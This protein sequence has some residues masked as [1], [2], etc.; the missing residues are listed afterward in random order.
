M[1]EAI[2]H[3]MLGGGSQS[4]ECK[5]QMTRKLGIRYAVMWV[6]SLFDFFDLGYEKQEN[7]LNPRVYISW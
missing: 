4:E 7:G 5:I 1:G 3:A 6:N 2:L